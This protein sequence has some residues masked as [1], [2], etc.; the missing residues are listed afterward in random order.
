M[1]KFIYLVSVFASAL[2][3]SQISVPGYTSISLLCLLVYSA[4]RVI[5]QLQQLK[6]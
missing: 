1:K 4:G 3:E 5:Y 6:I 2:G